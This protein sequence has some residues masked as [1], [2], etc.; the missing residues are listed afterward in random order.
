M[1]TK[2]FPHSRN[3]A[4]VV[5]ALVAGYVATNAIR[6]HTRIHIRTIQRILLNME[7]L[8]LVD[9]RTTHRRNGRHTLWV[10]RIGALWN[11]GAEKRAG[12]VLRR[13]K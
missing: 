6:N 1:K 5:L 9:H 11:T 13:R 8:G 2:P 3:E 12:L 10:P 4:K 7:L